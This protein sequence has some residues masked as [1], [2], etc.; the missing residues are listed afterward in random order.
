M[1]AGKYA[2]MMRRRGSEFRYIHDEISGGVFAFSHL[3]C[4]AA[5][6]GDAV[7]VGTT[8]YPFVSNL[9]PISTIRTDFPTLS[10]VVLYDQINGYDKPFATN[11]WAGGRDYVSSR[12]IF[13]PSGFSI[14]L[15]DP[16][17]I[18]AVFDIDATN[19]AGFKSLYNSST[20]FQSVWS[21]GTGSNELAMRKKNG[22]PQTTKRWDTGALSGWMMVAIT[23]DGSLDGSGWEMYFNDMSTPVSVIST[24]VQAVTNNSLDGIGFK[25]F[26]INA[27]SATGIQGEYH[28][29]DRVLSTSELQAFKTAL[30]QYPEYAANLP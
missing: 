8:N 30:L 23:D 15:S 3:K 19:N 12:Q 7:T 11:T 28:L 10:G 14:G 17:T 9:A 20:I 18:I 21:F 25:D 5:Y 16:K 24:A 29:F 26:Q 2:R 1:G 22:T 13:K 6:A 27:N 4:K